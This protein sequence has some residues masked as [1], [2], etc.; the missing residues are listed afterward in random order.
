MTVAVPFRRLAGHLV[1]LPVR[2]GDAEAP[3]VL[4][5]GIG[6][7][8]LTGAFAGR[9]GA[10]ATG[11]TFSGQR[12]S[13]QTVTAPLVRVPELSVGGHRFREVTAARFELERLPADLAPI[14]GFLGLSLFEQNPLVVD[15]GAEVVRIEPGGSRRDVPAGEV[16]V[17]ARPR[18]V[19]PSV[20][21][22]VDLTLPSGR[23]ARVEVD[24]G[25]DALILHRRYMAELGLSPD[26]PGVR[27]V[28]GR[29]ET[30]HAY[31][32]FGATL[33]GRIQLTGAP[34]FSQD[35]PAVVFQ[36]IIHDGLIGDAFLRRY[37]VRFDVGRARIGFAPRTTGS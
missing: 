3:F 26:G 24:M 1:V 18:R 4:D 21:L 33:A 5:S 8:L 25:S 6:L 29:D 9:A 17:P 36:E 30:G 27:T 28:R 23:V 13:G 35:A 7:T 22:E 14:G 31:V 20:D 16:E 10:A 37:R 19:G 15:Y 12:M 11:A 2:C 32:R 34:A